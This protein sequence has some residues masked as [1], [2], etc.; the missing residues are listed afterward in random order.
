MAN[1]TITEDSGISTF[2]VI[3]SE[4]FPIKPLGERLLLQVQAVEDMQTDSGIFLPAT[5][6]TPQDTYKSEVIAIGPEVE[7]VGPGDLV[8]ITAYAGDLVEYD[9]EEYRIIDQS[10]VLAIIQR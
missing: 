6:R 4:E 8:L 3:Q 7:L 5:G 1:T 2:P 10:D 9:M